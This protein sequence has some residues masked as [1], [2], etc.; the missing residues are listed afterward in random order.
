[1]SIVL[2][3]S[4]R[5]SHMTRTYVQI[6]CV[7]YYLRRTDVLQIF[8]IF[9]NNQNSSLRMQTGDMSAVLL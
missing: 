6:N 4:H 2:P 5:H 8:K 9:Q 7:L 3:A 1:M